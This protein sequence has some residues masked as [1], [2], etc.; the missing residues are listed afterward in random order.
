[1]NA[2][3]TPV[4]RPR[5][6]GAVAIEAALIMAFV[7]LP[8]MAFVLFLGRYFWY[9]SVAQKAAHDA[10]LYMASAPL[11]EIK[12]NSAANLAR[13]ITEQETGDL[14]AA[15]VETMGVVINCGYRIPANSSVITPFSCNYNSTPAIIQIGITLTV[16]DPFFSAVTGTLGVGG[17]NIAAGATMRYVG[18]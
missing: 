5:Q 2:R 16:A 8:V 6:R 12:N 18:R 10:T 3:V 14:D 9:Y 11:V 7:M 1:M 17:L 13:Y 4:R 15:T